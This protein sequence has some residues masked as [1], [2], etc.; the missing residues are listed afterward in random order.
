ML[1][2]SESNPH[3]LALP[4]TGQATPDSPLRVDHLTIGSDF[5][6]RMMPTAGILRRQVP[7]VEARI[8]DKG[9]SF[10][11]FQ[12]VRLLEQLYPGQYLVG[13]GG[14]PGG[15]AVRFRTD[16]SLSYPNATVVGVDPPTDKFPKPI[17]TVSFLGLTGP[18]GVLPQHYTEI[19]LSMDRM[20]DVP[21][22]HAFRDWLEIFNNRMI[23]AFFWAWEKYRF[24]IPYER[25]EFE[26]PEPD[27]FTRCLF[28][29]V[30]LGMP[31]LRTR[32]RV[33]GWTPQSDGVSPTQLD[34]IDDVALLRYVG[35]LS[36]RP[37]SAIAL[38]TFLEDFFQLKVEIRQFEG[39][40]LQIERINQTRLGR[41]KGN[42]LLGTNA[43]AGERVWS[44]ESKVRI[45]VGPLNYKDFNEYLPDRSA[46]TDRKAFFLL[47]QLVR[48]YIGLQLDVSIQLVLAADEVPEAQLVDDGSIGPRLGWNTWS[49]T[50]PMETNADDAVFETEDVICVNETRT[51]DSSAILATLLPPSRRR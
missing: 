42:N 4:A 11:F 43:I 50:Q 34:R 32:L 45:R 12:A 33:S 27:P 5:S 31:S 47:V 17:M 15:E 49:R 18:N 29:L 46:T 9:Y 6:S 36:H 16:L 14:P 19:L 20:G 3:P 1:D 35:I 21:E 38:R 41:H 48:L 8:F 26:R 37:R 13:R 23:S 30:G 44:V 39:Q 7:S 40:W 51:D 22:K 2:H 10:D 25:R 28:S 24:F